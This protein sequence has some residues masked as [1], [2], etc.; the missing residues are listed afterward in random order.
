MT[1]LCAPS[2]GAMG[3]KLF[4]FDSAKVSPKPIAAALRYCFLAFCCFLSRLALLL[5]WGCSLLLLCC[6]LCSTL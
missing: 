5:G 4:Y 1:I 3:R 6:L 2:R